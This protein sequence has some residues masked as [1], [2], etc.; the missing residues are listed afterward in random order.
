MRKLLTTTLSI[1][2]LFFLLCSCQQQL[3]ESN[4]EDSEKMQLEARIDSVAQHF[5]Q[6][7][8]VAGFSIAVLQDYDTL[9]AKGFGYSDWE[10]KK[11]VTPETVFA[12]ASITKLHTAIASLMLVEEG[13]LSLDQSLQEA[14]PDFPKPDQGEK[15]TIRHLL[16]HTSGLADYAEYMD[17][18]YI[19]EQIFPQKEDYFSFFEQN[20]LLFE[21]GTQYD[22]TNSGFI[23]MWMII[24]KASGML[25]EDIIERRIAQPLGLKTLTHLNRQDK[26]QVARRYDKKDSTFVLSQ[27]DTT[28]YFKGDGGLSA[29]ALDLAHVPFGIAD[30]KLISDAS[31]EKLSAPFLFED[32]GKSDYGLGFR[33][34]YFEG[35]KVWG[36][37][38]GHVNYWSTLAYYP[39]SRTSIVV[40]ANTDFS[41]ADALI[42]EGRVALAVFNMKEPDL[43]TS[44]KQGNLN[45]YTGQYSRS[46]EAYQDD[47]LL[48]LLTYEDDPE[49]LY[50][51]RKSS[52]SRGGRLVFLGNHTFA[53]PN[54]PMDRLV[55]DVNESGAVVGYRDYYNGLF[56]QRRNKLK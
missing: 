17:S 24:E 7:G 40:F 16:S 14:L 47:E 42:I 8:E 26:N 53:R 39:E 4:A 49:H 27:M 23:L 15:I 11:P 10:K 46:K 2:C 31:F 38:G 30:R 13:K 34:G 12:M 48:Q 52:S 33:Q 20:E 56:V 54:Y 35:R 28:F 32:G 51:K 37:T 25:Y 29:T 1:F 45:I 3:P 44:R 18:L 22:Y 50:I 43:A 5:L 21:P 9:Y 6:T 19:H 55:F 36:H 41:D